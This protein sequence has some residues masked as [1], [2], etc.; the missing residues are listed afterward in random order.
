MTQGQPI[1]YT[2]TGIS[3]SVQA[4]SNNTLVTGK[5]V[6]FSMSNGYEGQLFIPD[7]VFGDIAAVRAAIAGEAQMVA[8]AA[9]LTGNVG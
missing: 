5:L 2:V 6:L 7:S 3:R 9:A 4:T 1:T 8:A